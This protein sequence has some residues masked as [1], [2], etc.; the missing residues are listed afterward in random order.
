MT[1]L[2]VDV[3]RR[4]WW[5]I[6][7]FAL[8][9]VLIFPST[10]EWSWLDPNAVPLILSTFLATQ[11]HTWFAAREFAQLPVSRRSAW[12]AAWWIVVPLTSLLVVSAVQYAFWS[13]RPAEWSWSGTAMALIY[14]LL[15]TGAFQAIHETKLG[16]IGNEQATLSNVGLWMPVMLVW[17]AGPALFGR[18]LPHRPEEIGPVTIGLLIVC[19]VLAV[20][21]Y[22]YQPPIVARPSLRLARVRPVSAPAGEPP[23]VTADEQAKRDERVRSLPLWIRALF[24]VL[25]IRPDEKKRGV[26]DRLDGFRLLVWLEARRDLIA[27][28]TAIC[29]L[30]FVWLFGLFHEKGLVAWRHFAGSLGFLPFAHAIGTLAD[31]MA[32]GVF[33]FFASMAMHE[34]LDH[35]RLLRTLPL[36]A[37]RLIARVVFIS[38]VSA[39]IVWLTLLLLHFVSTRALP[40]SARLDVFM[41][42]AAMM[43]LLSAVRLAILGT[44][45]P[46]P[47]PQAIGITIPCTLW[48]AAF[49]WP[50]ISP[51]R[52]TAF[53]SLFVFT[54]GY[55][56]MIVAVTRS[57][58][59]YRALP[60]IGRFQ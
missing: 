13:A 8:Q 9:I 49:H 15:Y 21:G 36:S 43:T 52:S 30:G 2:I 25:D 18:Y 20:S 27:C 56:V 35:I 1:A 55:A 28:I 50:V 57:S 32:I 10:S 44:Q 4:R 11:G 22:R 37:N 6:A 46:Q 24:F 31:T 26:A 12:L 42:A 16:R 34:R 29:F 47:M 53:A 48:Y 7:L 17:V 39:V 54:L 60:V 40:V 23:V 51:A 5:R 14:C 45:I 19:L 38:T 41:S 58:R 33:G 59:I 3:I